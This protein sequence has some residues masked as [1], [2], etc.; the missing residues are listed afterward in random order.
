[1]CDVG[2][3]DRRVVLLAVVGLVGQA[4]SG[5]DEGDHVAGGVVGVGA[6]V[7]ADETSDTLAHEAAHFAGEFLVGGARV[8]RVEVGA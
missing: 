4:D 7:C 6:H 8:D 3:T 5:L 1:M 2:L